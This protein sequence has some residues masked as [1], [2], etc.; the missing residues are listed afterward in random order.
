MWLIKLPFRI[1]ALPIMALIGTLSI[2]YNLF[3]KI[4]S[5]AIGFIYLV[6]GICI[7]SCLVQQMWIYVVLMLVVGTIGFV[8]VMF[9]EALAMGLEALIGKLVRFIFT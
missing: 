2:F 8:G 4:G 5:F 1:I 6:L 7:I 3:L 9:A